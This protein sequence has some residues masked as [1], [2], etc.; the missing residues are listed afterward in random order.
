MEAFGM[1]VVMGPEIIEARRRH[2]WVHTLLIG[3]NWKWEKWS[4]ASMNGLRLRDTAEQ[5]G[6][7]ENG[8][9]TASRY[10]RGNKMVKKKTKIR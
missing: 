3:G 6:M 9:M 7:A 10:D 8:R 2:S 4:E 5:A 1:A